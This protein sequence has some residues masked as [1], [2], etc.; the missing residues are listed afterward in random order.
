M[1]RFTA[2]AFKS[3]SYMS[4]KASKI[5]NVFIIPDIFHS[6]NDSSFGILSVDSTNLGIATS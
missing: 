2:K 3:R 1:N 4:A 5:S 6:S